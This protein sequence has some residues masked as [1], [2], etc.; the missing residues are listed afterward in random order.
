MKKPRLL[1]LDSDVVITCYE[2]GIWQELKA[3]YDVHVTSIVATT[4]VM[5]FKDAGRKI[6]IDLEKQ[7]A[8][9]E[10]VI[11]EA[12]AIEMA[13]IINLFTNSFAQGI[14][15]GELE[16]LAVISKGELESCKFCTGDTN[17]IQAVGMLALGEQSISLEE[18]LSLAGIKCLPPH[19]LPPH[20][21]QRNRDLQVKTGSGRRITGEC[22]KK[23]P[24]SLD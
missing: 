5:H 1:L 17:S 8:N 14:D 6:A 12:T 23:S 11:V 19:S 10:I 15:D 9:G 20:F 18:V 13:N 7:A 4:E 21:S 3:K 2:I 16:G 24:L 22:F